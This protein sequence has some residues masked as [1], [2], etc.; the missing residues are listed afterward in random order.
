MNN[1]STIEDIKAAH[2]AACG[3]FFSPAT[4]RLFGSRILSPVFPGGIF[5]TSERDR[6][7]FTRN[8]YM[9]AWNGERRYT[10]RVCDDHGDIDTVSKFGQFSTRNE[11]L[12]WAHQYSAGVIA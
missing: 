1:Y 4:M 7:V 3:Y 12:A 2:E 8:G 9:A 5:V 11:A 6:G 10:V